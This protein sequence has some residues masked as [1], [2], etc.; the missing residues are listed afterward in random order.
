LNG[1][2]RW[3]LRKRCLC[4]TSLALA[5]ALLLGGMTERGAAQGLSEFDY[6]NLAFRGAGMFTGLIFP[7]KV[8]PTWTVGGR[9]DLGY[10]GPSIRILP[11]FT[12]WSSEFR[13][14]E[15]RRL[16]ERVEELVARELEPG[17]PVPS[18]DLGSIRWTDLVLGVDGQMVWSLPFD[19]LSYVGTGVAVHILNGDGE[20]INDTFVEDLLDRVTAGL[21]LHGGLEFLPTDRFRVF[22]EGRV[23]L[24]ENIQYLEL[25]VGAQVMV[26]GPAPGERRIRTLLR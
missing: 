11:T 20:A 12:W 3:G 1:S 17:T 15:V 10:L 7:T 2:A 22:G 25:R 9:M 4:G 19:G 6:E 8:E 23:E 14:S 24:L 16:E 5:T 26:G 18:I 21:N 13:R